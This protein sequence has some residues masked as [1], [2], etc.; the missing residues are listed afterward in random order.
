MA[1]INKT[2]YDLEQVENI[3]LLL[4][5]STN[6]FRLPSSMK[7]FKDKYKS[8]FLTYKKMFKTNSL[9]VSN[10]ELLEKK[11]DNDVN[12]VLLPLRLSNFNFIQQL[13]YGLENVEN[14]CNKH[15]IYK[16][17]LSKQALASFHSSNLDLDKYLNIAFSDKRLEVLLYK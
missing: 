13:M 15:D 17:A 3:D 10:C 11:D 14:I 6:V 1:L 16:I 8:K 7:W 2:R 12:V 9:T 5:V 4:P